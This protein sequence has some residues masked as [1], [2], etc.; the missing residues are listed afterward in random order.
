MHGAIIC[1]Q[2]ILVDGIKMTPY[3]S[4]HTKLVT[5]C[6]IT[7]YVMFIICLA[8]LQWHHTSKSTGSSTDSYTNSITLYKNPH[9]MLILINLSGH[10]IHAIIFQGNFG[11]YL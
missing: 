7:Y 5:K 10:F 8:I 6:S 2:E 1:T 9:G 11:V 4:Y 3:I